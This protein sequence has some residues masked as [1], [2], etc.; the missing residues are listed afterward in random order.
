MEQ[1]NS[2]EVE[3]DVDTLVQ[4]VKLINMLE[5]PVFACTYYPVIVKDIRLQL[6]ETS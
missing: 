5:S 6:L 1:L 3:Q 4:I 2:S